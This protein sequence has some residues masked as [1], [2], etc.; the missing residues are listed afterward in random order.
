MPSNNKNAI[1]PENIGFFKEI[2]LTAKLIWRLL[3]DPRINLF[4]KALPVGSFLYLLNPLDIPTPLDDAAIIWLGM[5][6]FLEICPQ[7]I[8]EEYR[9]QIRNE[10]FEYEIHEDIIEGEFSSV[11]DEFE[12]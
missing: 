3:L 6:F 2:G 9:I 10:M 1:K 5:T 11:D 12:N 4:A 8:V 7:D